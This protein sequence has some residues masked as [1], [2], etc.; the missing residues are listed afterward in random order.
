[1]GNE[2]GRQLSNPQYGEYIY[3]VWGP[4]AGLTYFKWRPSHRLHALYCFHPSYARFLCFSPELHQ[5]GAGR[6]SCPGLLQLARVGLGAQSELK[7]IA[8]VAMFEPNA[9]AQRHSSR[10]MIWQVG[11]PMYL[12]PEDTAQRQRTQAPRL[13][14]WMGSALDGGDHMGHAGPILHRRWESRLSLGQTRSFRMPSWVGREVGRFV[15]QCLF[16]LR[17][18]RTEYAH[19]AP[20]AV[21]SGCLSGHHLLSIYWGRSRAAGPG[22]G[23]VRRGL[24]PDACMESCGVFTSR[25]SIRAFG[26]G[27]L[28]GPMLARA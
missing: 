23:L 20:G 11:C 8:A 6:D 12:T 4:C 19:R 18:R 17:H 13:V 28:P 9:T 15:F 3:A 24:H 26:V 10:N 1:V 25:V 14:H 7:S 2:Y 22:D 21:L 16:V 5:R 27:L